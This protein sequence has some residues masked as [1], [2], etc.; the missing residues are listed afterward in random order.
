MS[1]LSDAQLKLTNPNPE[2]T[3][4]AA[5]THPGMAHFGGTGPAGSFCI[6]CEFWGPVRSAASIESSFD[7]FAKGCGHGGAIKPHR[8][9][10]FEQMTRMPAPKVPS[11]A[12]ACKYFQKAE[13]SPLKYA[14]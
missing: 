14:K 12:M 9:R 2:V 4:L 11:D 7:Y 10:K 3:N 5:N 8:C 6:D 13:K 1:L